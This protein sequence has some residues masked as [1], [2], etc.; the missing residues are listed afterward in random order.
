[1]LEVRAPIVYPKSKIEK[2][3]K[4]KEKWILENISHSRSISQ[5]RAKFSINY[6]DTI[7]L[8]GREYKLI[9][10]EKGQTGFIDCFYIPPNLSPPQIKAECIKIYRLLAKQHFNKRVNY[11]SLQM[12][13]APLSVKV[14]GARTRWGSCSYKKNI[15]FTWFLIMAPE[16]TIDYVIVHEMAHLTEM[17][18]SPK[19]WA[20][21]ENILPDYQKRRDAL[22]V[23]QKRLNTENWN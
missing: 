23:L 10:S 4:L 1:M 22:K 8:L 17:N 11:F 16:D 2:F 20:I 12:G 18:H 3:I 13:V 6:G 15:N 7:L 9:K 14:N 5:I 21:V 19:F